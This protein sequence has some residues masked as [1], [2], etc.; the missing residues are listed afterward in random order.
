MVGIVVVS[1]SDMLAEGVV[2]LAREMAS[3]DLLIE[4]AGG[5]AEPGVLGTDAERVR[6]AIERVM[7]PDGVLVMMDLGSALMSAEF[8]VEL[9]EGAPGPVQLSDAPLVEGTVAAAVAASSGSSLA[10]VAGEARQ[11]LEMKIA[12]IGSG[13]NPRAAMEHAGPADP[14]D[15]DSVRAELPV[16]NAIGLH[17]RPAA[18]ITQ[19]VAAYDADVRIARRGG[20]GAAVGARSLTNILTLGVRAGDTIIVTA[21]GPQASAAIDALRELAQTGF[22]DGTAR[23]DTG[24]RSGASRDA[25]RDSPEAENSGYLIEEAA[26]APP[27]GTTLT[28]LAASGGVAV[29]TAHQLRAGAEAPPSR[30]AGSPREELSL[31]E[32]GLVRTRS[33]LSDDRKRLGAS[34]GAAEAAIFDA[35]LALVDDDALLEPARSAIEGGATAEG[36]IHQAAEQLARVYRGLSVPLLAQRATDVLDVGQRVVDALV[37]SH[38]A[39]RSPEGIVI[40]DE[41]TPSQTSRFD[42]ER[43]TAIA[44]ARGSLTTHAA[45][46]ARSLGI[47]AVLGLGAAILSVADG[48]TV[49]VDGEAGDVVVSPSHDSA[50]EALGRRE[51]LRTRA[52]AVLARAHEPATLASGE[53]IEIYANIASVEDAMRAVVL[54]AEGVGMLR[55]EFLYLDRPE[56]PQEQEQC[57]TL[58]QIADAL[59]GRPLIVRTLDAGADKPLTALPMAPEANPFLGMRGIRVGL[60]HPDLLSTQLRAILR[61]A[62]RHPVMMMMPMVA[63]LGEILATRRLLEQARADLGIHAPLPLGITL[64]VPSAALMSAQLARDVD[65]FSIGTNDLTQYTMAAERGDARLA[66]LIA[67]PQPAVLRMIELTVAGAAAASGGT[68]RSCWVGVCGEM[69]GDPASAV[70]LVGLGVTELSMAPGLI[71]ELKATLR[72]VSLADA[73]RAAAAA[74]QAP[75]AETARRIALDLL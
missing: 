45:I 3:P 15:G 42:P 33:T 31:L 61:A 41:L 66:G 68:G 28:G 29:G 70:L 8:A 30:S 19:T 21:S 40:A 67:S 54:G 5:I 11:A 27:P 9:L 38:T 69:G 14:S 24:T 6:G 55:T 63:T 53:R 60:Q 72:G 47:P 4:P 39:T 71:P 59:K 23:P 48:T 50:D 12:Q 35:H 37:G 26:P 36:A 13:E 74:L 73:R 62:R 57:E 1:H 32:L 16:L 34:V 10:E 58:V 22:G 75:D 52:A 44:T 56:L 7:A 25:T 49:L 51:R 20:T 18:R 43:V 46:I 65:F 17:A 2:R 64:E